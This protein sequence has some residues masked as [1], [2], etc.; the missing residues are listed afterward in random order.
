[1]P[2]SMKD[3]LNALSQLPFGADSFE[4]SGTS[5]LEHKAMFVSQLPFGADS[6]ESRD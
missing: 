1:M 4:S 5:R 3:K 6:F 2:K